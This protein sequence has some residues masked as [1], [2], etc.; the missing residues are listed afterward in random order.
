MCAFV[1][2]CVYTS[3]NHLAGRQ[4][5]TQ[6]CKPTVL[7]LKTKNQKQGKAVCRRKVVGSEKRLLGVHVRSVSVE[8]GCSVTSKGCLFPKDASRHLALGC[9]F[10]SARQ[11]E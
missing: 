5:L 6:H 4:K 8:P 1:Y 2:I 7:Q 11:G 9:H 10:F 3:R